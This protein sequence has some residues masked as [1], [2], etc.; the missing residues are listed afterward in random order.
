M[1]ED[2]NLGRWP[3]ADRPFKNREARDREYNKWLAAE[4]KRIARQ[5]RLFFL[6]PD[7]PEKDELKKAMIDRAW[8][9]LDA[10]YP[11]ASDQLLEFVPE[12]D[13]EAMHAEYFKDEDPKGQPAAAPSTTQGAENGRNEN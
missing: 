9:L 4:Q 1:A 3:S 10:G 5:R 11:G 13:A 12:A 7:G 8:D 2:M 6:I